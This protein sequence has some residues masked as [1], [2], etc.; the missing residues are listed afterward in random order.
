MQ[1]IDHTLATTNKA[2]WF[3]FSLIIIAVGHCRHHCHFYPNQII[4]A[5]TIKIQLSLRLLKCM[6]SHIKWAKIGIEQEEKGMSF[7]NRKTKR[8]GK[9][10][11]ITI[12]PESANVINI[13]IQS[14]F[15]P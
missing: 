5:E 4:I 3:V 14:C 1:K 10:A 9:N 2:Q 6:H 11:H 13:I 7:V 8:P 12:F 15:P